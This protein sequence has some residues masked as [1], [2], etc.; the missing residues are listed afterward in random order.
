MPML[1]SRAVLRT[2][3]LRLSP[4]R[5]RTLEGLVDPVLSKARTVHEHMRDVFAN[6]LPR[7]RTAPVLG[8]CHGARRAGRYPKTVTSRPRTRRMILRIRLPLRLRRPPTTMVAVGHPGPQHLR[9]RTGRR[10]TRTRTSVPII[11]E[12]VVDVGDVVSIVALGQSSTAN[13]VRSFDLATV[14]SSP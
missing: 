10:P 9:H 5:S 7:G 2:P 11:A 13:A 3:S 4:T 14:A 8:T 6:A 12:G 1:A